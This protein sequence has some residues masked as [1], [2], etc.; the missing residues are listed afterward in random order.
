MDFVDDDRAHVRQHLSPRRGRQQH[1]QRLG[2]RDEDVRRA[3]AQ[4]G[5]FGL[6]RVAGAH[7]GADRRHRQAELRERF[8]DAGE[9]RIEVHVDVVRQRF[10]RRYVHDERRVGQ[11]A[12]VRQRIAHQIVERA[13]EGGE[14]LAGAG[15]CRNERR[16]AGLDVR[17]SERLR[18]GGRGERAPE[19][20]GDSRVEH[21]ERT[22]GRAGSCDVHRSVEMGCKRAEG[23]LANR[24]VSVPDVARACRA[25]VSAIQIQM[26]ACI[27]LSTNEKL[28]ARWHADRASNG[29]ELQLDAVQPAEPLFEQRRARPQRL[30]E[31]QRAA[32]C[33]GHDDQVAMPAVPQVQ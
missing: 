13:Q 3:L 2:R 22:G 6:R 8:G 17:P 11:R 24:I 10:Q 29:D 19:P 18:A 14:R 12:V 26:G 5:T 32:P 7:G 9:R 15:R 1:V 33:G 4:C 31:P 21:V 20:R 30:R 25:G 27:A 28:H 16:S 23:A